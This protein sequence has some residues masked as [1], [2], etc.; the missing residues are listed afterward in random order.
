MAA[1]TSS[2]LTVI[3]RVT[4]KDST[5]CS[6]VVIVVKAE[7][8]RVELALERAGTVIA[9]IQVENIR[10]L[11]NV[12]G[13][14]AN[15]ANSKPR[16]SLTVN[17]LRK[18]LGHLQYEMNMMVWTASQTRPLPTDVPELEA[19]PNNAMLESFLSHARNLQDFFY[20][21]EGAEATDALA[22]DFFSDPLTWTTRRPAPSPLLHPKTGTLKRLINK[23]L[24]HLT[25]DRVSV[26]SPSG[27]WPVPAVRNELLAV[28]SSFRTLVDKESL[29]DSSE[30]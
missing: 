17:D 8:D 10:H 18:L 22:T 3:D 13:R 30:C 15:I 5:T 24:A 21:D 4:C 25:W 27:A 6:P 19:L 9:D 29:L 28:W 12:V 1:S 11:A 26:S 2:N 16:P 23:Q 14:A 20:N 7:R